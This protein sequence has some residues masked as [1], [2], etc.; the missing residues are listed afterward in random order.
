MTVD[1]EGE[2]ERVVMRAFKEGAVISRYRN[3]GRRRQLRTLRR[4]GRQ[5][6]GV[7]VR[8]IT[9]SLVWGACSL[10]SVH[11]GNQHTPSDHAVA[12]VRTIS[13][14]TA[15]TWPPTPVNCP[16]SK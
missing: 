13:Y 3:G 2:G 16:A 6:V 12:R 4:D 10:V 14:V 15:R 1:D 7:R 8:L 11:F 9:Q 5:R